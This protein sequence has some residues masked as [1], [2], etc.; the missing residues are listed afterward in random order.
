MIMHQVTLKSQG[1]EAFL[2]DNKLKINNRLYNLVS[3]Q[4]M[5]CNTSLNVN[6]EFVNQ[7]DSKQVNVNSRSDAQVKIE[8]NVGDFQSRKV[9]TS[10]SRKRML[11]KML[12]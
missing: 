2:R 10:T 8:S 4:R 5:L 12:Q 3:I 7:E 9:L 11:R 1:I 6:K